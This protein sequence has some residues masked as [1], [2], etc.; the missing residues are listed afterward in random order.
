MKTLT[1]SS[2]VMAVLNFAF[3]ASAPLFAQ[4]ASARSKEVGHNRVKTAPESYFAS[5]QEEEDYALPPRTSHSS[6]GLVLNRFQDDFG[7]GAVLTTPYFAKDR[8][9]MRFSINL[10]FFEGIPQNKSN[11]EWMPYQ[12]YKLGLIAVGQPIAKAVRLYGEGGIAYVKPNADFSDDNVFGGYGLF[13]F[14]FIPIPQ[15]SYFIELGGAGTGSK[16]EKI[17][18]APIYFNGFSISTGFKFYFP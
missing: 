4:A 16:A 10:A 6:L 13:G 15:Y 7:L 11:E 1:S 9:A 5:F 8:I 18:G 3:L 12:A 14:E 2:M 17:S